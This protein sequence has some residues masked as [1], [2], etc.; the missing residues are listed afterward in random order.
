MG[1]KLPTWCSSHS[2]EPKELSCTI[3]LFTESWIKQYVCVWL[4]SLHSWHNPHR[5]FFHPVVEVAE[6]SGERWAAEK[7]PIQEVKIVTRLYTPPKETHR[8][9]SW[10]T[11]NT[12]N[13]PRK[14]RAEQ[15][16]SLYSVL[17]A[18]LWWGGCCRLTG[19]HGAPWCSKSHQQLKEGQCSSKWWL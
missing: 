4:T 14:M 11:N 2:A 7:P 17:F 6:G 13:T 1:K 9:T 16:Q 10:H 19:W 3:I 8:L 15:R 5:L 12:N 18:C